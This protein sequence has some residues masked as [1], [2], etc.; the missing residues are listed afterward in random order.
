MEAG[1]EGG[2]SPSHHDD[3]PRASFALWRQPAA[4]PSSSKQTFPTRPPPTLPR[5]NISSQEFFS[6]STSKRRFE[7]ESESEECGNKKARIHDKTPTVPTTT[8]HVIREY[9]AVLQEFHSS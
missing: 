3:E 9:R 8:E 4:V 6:G 2:A 5:Q 7:E 1:D